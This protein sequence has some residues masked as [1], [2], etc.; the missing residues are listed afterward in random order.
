MRMIRDWPYAHN[1]EKTERR[2]NRLPEL[3]HLNELALL[4]RRLDRTSRGR[5][6]FDPFPRYGELGRAIDL[7]WVRNGHELAQSA[8]ADRKLNCWNDNE[9]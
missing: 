3:T 5:P 9:C 1:I 8:F 6:E 4:C 2:G 7:T